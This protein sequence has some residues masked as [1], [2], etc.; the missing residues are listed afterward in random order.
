MIPDTDIRIETWPP[1][2]KGGQHAGVSTGVRVE[3]LPSG[4]VIIITS[5]RSQRHNAKI[6]RDTLLAAITHPEFGK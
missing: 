2:T 4:T 5:C 1:S 3:H 6:A